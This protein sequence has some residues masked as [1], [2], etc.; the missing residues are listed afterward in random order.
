MRT[1]TDWCAF[2]LPGRRERLL[3]RRVARLCSDGR[4]RDYR[5]GARSGRGCRSRCDHHGH[6]DP[7]ESSASGGVH[8]RWCLHRPEPRARRVPARYRARRFQTPAPRGH[9]SGDRREGAH[10]FR[11]RGRRPAG[12]GD[13]GR[14]RAGR[15]RGDREPRDRRRERAG[16]AAAV[17]R[18]PVHHA[19]RHRAWRRP[20]AEFRPAAH[21]R[22]ETAN[23]RV[24][25]RRHLRAAARAGAA[26]LLPDHRRHP[27]V[28]DREQQSG[29]RVRAVQWR[30]GQSHD[31]IGHQCLP[32][33]PV[34]VL[35]QR[36]SERQ[37]LLPEEPIR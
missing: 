34:R 10:R 25:L 32:R 35:S 13:S 37:E 8:G 27:G 15:A 22:R 4:R 31:E 30:R 29:G 2:H 5:R 12:T 21:Q 1:H 26:R 19:R 18:P 28:Q 16:R 3:H 23:E 11:S 24:S 6:R 9:S 17:E 36:A 7:D 20:A 33:Q 14:G